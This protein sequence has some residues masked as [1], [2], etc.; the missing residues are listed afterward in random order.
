MKFT[1]TLKN[2]K[3]VKIFLLKIISNIIHMLNVKK[4]LEL[5]TN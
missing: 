1:K 5:S 3:I 2:T 4:Q